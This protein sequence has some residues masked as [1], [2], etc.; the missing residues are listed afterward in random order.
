LTVFNRCKCVPISLEN[1]FKYLLKPNKCASHLYFCTPESSHTIHMLKNNW[2]FVQRWLFALGNTLHYPSWSTVSEGSCP[3]IRSFV[4]WLTNWP[5]NWQHLACSFAL[6]AAWP[7]I[8][9]HFGFYLTCCLAFVLPG[10][11][12]TISHVVFSRA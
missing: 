8:W 2:S 11:V 12:K 1:E 10:S 5:T 4:F 9:H 3:V 6:P 7:P